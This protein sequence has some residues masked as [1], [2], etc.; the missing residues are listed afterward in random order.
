MY[1]NNRCIDLIKNYTFLRQ[2]CFVTMYMYYVHSTVGED[3]EVKGVRGETLRES[4]DDFST[5]K[6]R[7]STSKHTGAR[8]GP[9]MVRVEYISPFEFEALSGL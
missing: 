6:A 4:D 8:H 3:K 5:V 9:E 2:L 7:R 1:A